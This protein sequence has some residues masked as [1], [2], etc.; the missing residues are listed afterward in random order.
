MSNLFKL[1]GIIAFG[2]FVYFN[3]LSQPNQQGIAQAEELISEALIPLRLFEARE[4]G[5]ATQRRAR[6]RVIETSLTPSTPVARA[7][8]VATIAREVGQR[9]NL[10]YIDVILYARGVEAGMFGINVA[11]AEYTLNIEKIPFSDVTWTLKSNDFSFTEQ[12][13]QIINAWTLL[14]KHHIDTN[15]DLNEDK[16]KE[17]IAKELGLNIEEIS[18]PYGPGL[19][20]QEYIGI[21]PTEEYGELISQAVE[22][23][24]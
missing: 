2:Y 10:D 18:I 19:T 1:I 13:I 15:G 22:L 3:F 14:R 9:A 8:A 21:K 7:K 6:L 5:T 20:T 24:R 12:Q 11:V 23:V 4:T 17:H 16:L